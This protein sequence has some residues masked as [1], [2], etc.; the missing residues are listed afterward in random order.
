M[1][2]KNVFIGS[3]LI[4]VA[5]I[6]FLLFVVFDGINSTSS[7][8]ENVEDS[9]AALAQAEREA[10]LAEL[11][12]KASDAEDL[13]TDTAKVIMNLEVN[14]PDSIAEMYLDGDTE[15]LSKELENY[16]AEED[17]SL[18]VTWAKCSNIV[19]MDH[20]HNIIYMEFSIN[21]GMGTTV[22]VE[23]RKDKGIFKFN[24]Y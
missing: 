11:N 22:T 13:D 24:Y 12:S 16:L 17:F 4:A 8:S 2:K 21:D 14:I 3:A 10:L 19:T 1:K 5:I 9:E 20:L 23:Y 6:I 7:A 15:R 18:D